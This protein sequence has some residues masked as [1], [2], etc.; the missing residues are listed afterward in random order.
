MVQRQVF[1]MTVVTAI[2]T[3]I[4]VANVYPRPLHRRFTSVPANMYVVPQPDNG[5]HPECCRRGTKDI[6]AVMFFDKHGAP[7]PQANRAGYTNRAERLIRK[8]QKQNSS[9]KQTPTPPSFYE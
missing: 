1:G 3:S 5:W 9:C 6:L 8:V 2:L 7:K 4:A